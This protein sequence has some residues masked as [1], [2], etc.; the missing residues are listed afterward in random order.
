M[1]RATEVARRIAAGKR[2][3]EQDLV[4]PLLEDVGKLRGGNVLDA[5]PLKLL[6]PFEWRPL[7]VLVRVIA[8][9]IRIADADMYEV[10]IRDTL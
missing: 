5:A 3:A 8:G 4:L 10:S 7:F 9:E 2:G 1:Q 6:G